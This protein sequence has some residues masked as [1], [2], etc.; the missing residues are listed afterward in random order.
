MQS[1]ISLILL[2]PFLTLTALTQT[3]A[4]P[5]PYEQAWTKL[6]TVKREPGTAF[7]LS[8]VRFPANSAEFA[9]HLEEVDGKIRARKISLANQD[10]TLVAK[11]SLGLERGKSLDQI[12]GSIQIHTEDLK[13]SDAD[14]KEALTELTKVRLLPMVDQADQ[15]PIDQDLVAIIYDSSSE[16]FQLRTTQQNA[17]IFRW[18]SKLEATTQKTARRVAPD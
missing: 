15:A 12:V 9:I 7:Q 16:S 11:V 14:L 17:D 3:L 13:L 1:V 18:V 2:F 10:E 8:I 5:T 6:F 4:C